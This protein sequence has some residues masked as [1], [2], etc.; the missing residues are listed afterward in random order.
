RDTTGISEDGQPGGPF[1][2]GYRERE[3]APVPRLDPGVSEGTGSGYSTI[4]HSRASGDGRAGHGSTPSRLAYG[5]D[6]SSMRPGPNGLSTWRGEPADVIPVFVM[7]YQ[8]NLY[9]PIQIFPI[10]K[11]FSGQRAFEPANQTPQTP[12]WVRRLS[13]AT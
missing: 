7:G 4:W 13:K 5:A 1:L 10:P 6:G 9:R 8:R 12:P 2:P 3:R 11:I